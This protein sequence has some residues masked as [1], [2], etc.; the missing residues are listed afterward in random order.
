MC[1]VV[2]D[3]DVSLFQMTIKLHRTTTT[4]FVKFEGVLSIELR[5]INKQLRPI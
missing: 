5:N 4:T 1:Q 3:T 2:I